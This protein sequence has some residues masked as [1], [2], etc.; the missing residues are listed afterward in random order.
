M[1]SIAVLAAAVLGVASI[2][3]HLLYKV[4]VHQQDLRLPNMARE[5]T[6]IV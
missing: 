3:I 2:S 5:Q 1:Q 6:R 4:S